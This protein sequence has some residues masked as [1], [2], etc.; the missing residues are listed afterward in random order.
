MN[1]T[2]DWQNY[3]EIGRRLG[4]CRSMVRRYV[5]MGLQEAA[6]RQQ[7]RRLHFERAEAWYTLNVNP[8]RSGS[9]GFRQRQKQAQEQAARDAGRPQ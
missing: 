3:A 8:R 5:G 9:W 1:L 6:G 7:D 4:I 2:P